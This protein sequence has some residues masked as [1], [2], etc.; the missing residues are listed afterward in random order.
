MAAFS[1]SPAKI[2]LKTST[3]NQAPTFALFKA[4]SANEDYASAAVSAETTYRVDAGASEVL[5]NVGTAALVIERR[6]YQRQTAP[7]AINATAALTAAAI[8]S[9]IV[10]STT[11]A[12]VTGT[13]PVATDLD[14]AFQM[15]IGDSIDFSVIATGANAFTV[16]VDTGVTAVG[17]LVVAT[18][19]SGL[20]RL[21]KTAV[22]T[23]IVYRLG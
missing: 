19:T 13:I 3:P 14:L 16:A 18:A 21:R 9:G 7:V 15:E 8:A 4:L 2:Y 23:Y 6:A 22:A 12:A 20:F 1:R 10:T 17:T 5:V 11:A